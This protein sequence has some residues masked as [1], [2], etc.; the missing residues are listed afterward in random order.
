VNRDLGFFVKALGFRDRIEIFHY[1][2]KTFKIIEGPRKEEHPFEIKRAKGRSS[3]ILD[4]EYPFGYVDAEIGDR[5]IYALYSG[6]TDSQMMNSSDFAK[7]VFVFTHAGE[8]IGRFDLDISV[9]S[10]AVDEKLEDLYGIRTDRNPGRAVFK[11]PED[12]LN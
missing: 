12:L 5:Y 4:F 3:V 2:S 6:L 1:L 11:I 9:R 7:T 10:I 8:L